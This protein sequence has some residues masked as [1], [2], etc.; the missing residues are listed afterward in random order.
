MWQKKVCGIVKYYIKEL[1]K[2]KFNY[3]I[4]LY[5]YHPQWWH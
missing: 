3:I 2:L 4:K 5:I 1:L